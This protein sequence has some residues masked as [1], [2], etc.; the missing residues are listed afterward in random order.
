MN[1]I[2]DENGQGLV[3]YGLVLG[4]IAVV[5]IVVLIAVGNKS[6]DVFSKANA[7]AEKAAV[8]N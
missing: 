4:L 3:E 8:S 2:K 5:A 1:F 6:R 7:E